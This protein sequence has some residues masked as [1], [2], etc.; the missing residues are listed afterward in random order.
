MCCC[1]QM[2]KVASEAPMRGR[3]ARQNVVLELGYFVGKAGRNRVC[4]LMRGGVEVPSDIVGVVFEQ[5]DAAGAW[6]MVLV[7]E[8][9]AAGYDVDAN[10]LWK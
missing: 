1:R 2:M 4:A 10:R 6:K 8:L 3:R 5:F 9:L 7:R